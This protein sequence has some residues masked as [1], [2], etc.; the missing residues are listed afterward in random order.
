MKRLICFFVIFLIILLISQTAFAV[1]TSEIFDNEDL[2]NV[3][4]PSST[5][6][7]SGGVFG[8][9]NTVIGLLQIAGTGISVLIVTILGIK[10]ILAS[11]GEKAEIK[12]QAVPIVI[13]AILLFGAVNIMAIV[14]NFANNSINNDII[15]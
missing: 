6:S 14:E 2:K 5:M 8:A 9:I 3:G 12:K 1:T 15:K 11:V 7:T 13:G 4:K 10:Y